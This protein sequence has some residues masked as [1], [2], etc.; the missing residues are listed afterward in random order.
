LYEPAGHGT[1]NSLQVSLNK[2]FSHGLQFLAS[3]TYAKDLTD[4]IG[5][6]NAEE[7]GSFVGNQLAPAY[8]PDPFVRPHRFVLSYVYALP[9]PK[10][11][12][13]LTKVAGGWETSGVATIQSGSYLS[14]TYSNTN[15][16]YGETGDRPN[17]TPGCMVATSGNLETRLL[18]GY[19]NTSCYSKP[20]ALATGS[21]ATGFG[22]APLAQLRGPDQ[23]NFDMAFFKRTA[24][25]WPTEVANI[26]FRT[27]MFNAFN[28]P[29]FGNPSTAFNTATF[30]LNQTG[31]QSTSPRIIQFALKVNF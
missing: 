22:D 6:A 9:S 31:A 29:Q 24:I 21:S 30:G 27:E 2:R 28:H 19:L 26:E 25:H 8:G 17:Y 14:V 20:L 4:A 15:N 3:Y 5:T 10:G 13:F 18:T 23:V 12:G 16:A 1:Y 7:A 11:N